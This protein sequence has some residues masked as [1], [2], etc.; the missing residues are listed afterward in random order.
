MGTGRTEVTS[1]G[2]RC[3]ATW[4]GEGGVLDT[5]NYVRSHTSSKHTWQVNTE[6]L[7]CSGFQLCKIPSLMGFD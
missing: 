3:E 4:P 1:C 6:E 2:V 5:G 7:F